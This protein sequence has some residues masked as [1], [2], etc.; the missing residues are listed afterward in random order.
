MAERAQRVSDFASGL[1]CAAQIM[2]RM[3]AEPSIAMLGGP[4]A[5]RIVAD[6]I[7]KEARAHRE[8]RVMASEV[9][10]TAL[11]R[12]SVSLWRGRWWL[13]R[14][15]P[16]HGFAPQVVGPFKSEAEAQKYCD[17]IN[18]ENRRDEERANAG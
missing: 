12:F 13:D 4:D 1:E 18:E 17:W 9:R 5:L 15:C 6:T 16:E 7:E 14:R 8:A 11:P 2:R 10:T 3:A